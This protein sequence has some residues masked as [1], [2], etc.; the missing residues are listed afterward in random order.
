VVPKVA[1]KDAGL[2][3]LVGVLKQAGD[4]EPKRRRGQKPEC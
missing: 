3:W 1:M 2:A 4:A